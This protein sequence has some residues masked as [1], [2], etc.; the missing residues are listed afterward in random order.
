MN[1]PNFYI[2]D[3]IK[4]A[5]EEDIN[6]VDLATDYLLDDED[7]SSASFIAKAEGVLCGINAALRVFTFID[8]DVKTE[9]MIK[10]GEPVKKGD[11]IAV[12]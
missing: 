5:L 10:D 7:M 8:S 3:I 1:L 6:Y 12:V 4:R 9:I 2:D 11:V